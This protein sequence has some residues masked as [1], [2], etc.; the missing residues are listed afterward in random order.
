[1]SGGDRAPVSVL[2]PVHAGIAA[3]ALSACL[4]SIAGQTLAAA[5]V[6]VVEDG[7]LGEDLRA[8]L[9]GFAA[10]PGTAVVRIALDRNRGA[11]AANDAGLRAATQE[12]VAK[13]DAD[14]ISLPHR[15]ATQWAAVSTGAVDV[16]G[17][18]MWEFEGDPANVVGLRRMPADD[19]AIRRRLRSN[20]PINHPTAMYRRDLAL[21]AGGYG[22]MRYLQDYDLFA[23]MSVNGS[24]MTN[25]AEPLVL[26]RAGEGMV[27]RRRWSPEM[28]E[29]ERALQANL[30]RYGVVGR[31][32]AAFNR[33]WRTAYRRLPPGLVGVVHRR[34]LSRRTAP[35]GA[36]EVGR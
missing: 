18:A 32:R 34:W 19:A 27:T 22:T 31:P 21:A 26:F 29:S 5:E 7:P 4:D 24:R 14:D 15:L 28:A 1:M 25:L 8:V 20:N 6:V 30:L 3:A 12:W 2:L 36:Q 16:C 13:A 35:P 23:R 33:V 11:G 10:G 17:S 9:D